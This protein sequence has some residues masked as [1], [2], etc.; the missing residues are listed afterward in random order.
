MPIDYKEYHPKWSLISRLIRFFRA[1]NCCEWCGAKNYHPHPK[2]GSK[3]VLTV[4]HIDHQRCHLN[5]DLKHHI[6]N[7]KYGKHWKT[8]I[9]IGFVMS[10]GG[11]IS[12]AIVIT[13]HAYQRGKERIGLN[14]KAFET[15]A[16]KAYLAG[17]KHANTKGELRN[18][19]SALY[20]QYRKANNIR[21]FGNHVY[22]FKNFTLITVVHLPNELK[23]YVTL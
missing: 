11:T 2:T 23:K 1:K 15:I 6:T 21:V 3:V 9:K 8:S 22:L 4:A 17:K 7:R 14:A 20:L 5:H 19:I 18:Y 13:D 16:L 10:K 12:L